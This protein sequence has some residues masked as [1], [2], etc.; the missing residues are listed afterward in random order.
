MAT[1]QPACVTKPTFKYKG[2]VYAH[3]A[4][5]DFVAAQPVPAASRRTLSV[6]ELQSSRATVGCSTSSNRSPKETRGGPSVARSCDVSFLVPCVRRRGPPA[7]TPLMCPGPPRRGGPSKTWIHAG[8]CEGAFA[9]AVG[10][11]DPNDSHHSL[12]AEFAQQ[13]TQL[14]V[15]IC[16]KFMPTIPSKDSEDLPHY[17]VSRSG[18]SSR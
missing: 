15:S 1:F 10:A 12:L 6:L 4:L 11:I 8:P 9:R 17:S 2:A 14:S 3:G 7:A 16:L 13:S 5:I 18:E